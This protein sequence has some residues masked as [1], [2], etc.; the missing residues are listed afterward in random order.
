MSHWLPRSGAATSV[1]VIV[2]GLVFSMIAIL[3]IWKG[4]SI[5]ILTLDPVVIADYPESVSQ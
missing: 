2:C 3:H 5:E 1:V 4:V